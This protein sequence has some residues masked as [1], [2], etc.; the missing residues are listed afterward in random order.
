M[1]LAPKPVSLRQKIDPSKKIDINWTKLDMQHIKWT[2]KYYSS[3]E[4]VKD[5]PVFCPD[6]HEKV[7]YESCS[8]STSE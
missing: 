3:R 7:Q 5:T 6:I 4:N 8:Y 2:K 1:T